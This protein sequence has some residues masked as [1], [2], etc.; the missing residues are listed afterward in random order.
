VTEF[1]DNLRRELEATFKEDISIYFDENLHDGLLETHNVDKS[2]EGKLNCLVFIP[3][4]SQ[5]YYD[6]KSFA[7]QNEFCAFNK[8]VKEDQ[9]G[10]EIRVTGGNVASRILPVKINDLDPEDNARI[11]EELGGFLRAIEFIYREPGVNRPLTPDDDDNKNLNKTKYRNQINKVAQAI[12]AIIKG[13]KDP[14]SKS[15]TEKVKIAEAKAEIGKHKLNWIKIAA[16]VTI[17]IALLIAGLFILTPVVKKMSGNLATIEKSIAIL[18][19]DNLSNDPDQEYFSIGI[20]DEILDKLFKIGDLKVIARTSSARFKNSTLSLKEIGRELGVSAI[21]EGSVQKSGDNIRITVQLIDTRNEAHLWS[22]IYDKDISD[23]FKIQSEVARTIARELKAMITPEARQLIEK[24]PTSDMEAYDAYLKGTFYLNKLTKKDME[25]ALQY[26]ELAK[27]KDPQFAMAYSGIS[28][29]WACRQ[30]MG[31]VKVS[32]A[33]P[34]TEAAI[35]KALELDNTQSEIHSTLAAIR[36][37]TR[38]DWKGGEVSY[39]KAIELNPN[40]EGAHSTF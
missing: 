17:I 34:K 19:F 18:P 40:N 31:I 3:V 22:E 35:M 6:P 2:L 9:F 25:T 12:K 4:I 28:R 33:T 26:F 30:Q 14:E 10:R 16:S 38:W 13:I 36:V 20:V 1:V 8:L 5:T 7:W 11:E 24:I 37:W 27:E 39:R 23:V 15:A 32:E 29:V 21:L